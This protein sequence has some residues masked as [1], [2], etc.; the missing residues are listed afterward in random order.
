MFRFGFRNITKLNYKLKIMFSLTV[1]YSEPVFFASS[2]L[3]H[4]LNIC[5]AYKLSHST[6]NFL[7]ILVSNTCSSLHSYCL[8]NTKVKVTMVVRLNVK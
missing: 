3:D 5:T 4:T 7:E 6:D 1:I 8:D 2:Y